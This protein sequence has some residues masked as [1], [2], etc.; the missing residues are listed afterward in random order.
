MRGGGNG[1]VEVVEGLG[2]SFV[3]VYDI[4]DDGCVIIVIINVAM[5]LEKTERYIRRS[6]GL[7]VVEVDMHGCG[8]VSGL[9]F[10]VVKRRVFSGS[11]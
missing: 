8:A 1:W 5:M 4:D 11:W 2:G 9:V 10:V 7:G 6:G 3:V